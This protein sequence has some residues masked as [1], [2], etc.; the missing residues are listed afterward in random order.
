MEA[1]MT[2]RRRSSRAVANDDSIRS[3]T[4]ELIL[5]D[6]IDAISFRDVGREAGL[7]HGALYARYEDVEELLVDLWSELLCQSM[8]AL[9]DAARNAASNPSAETVDALLDYVRNAQT[10]DVVAVQVLLTS[11]RF[12][13]LHEEVEKFIHDYIENHEGVTRAV[14]SRALALFSLVAV[15]I[16]TNSQY[17][18]DVERIQFLRE[19][20]LDALK[21]DPEDVLQTPLTTPDRVVTTARSDIRSQ[22]AFHTFSAVGRSGFT[23]ATISRISRRANCSP[24]AIYKLYPSKDD[25]VVASMRALM[26]GPGITATRLAEILNE[27]TLAQYLYVAA[28]DQDSVRKFFNLEVLMASTQNEKLKSAVESQFER[29]YRFEAFV[30][31]IPDEERKKFQF[32]IREVIVLILGVSFLSTLTPEAVEIDFCQFAEPFRRA[33]LSHFE[34]WPEISR[35]LKDLSTTLP[36]RYQDPK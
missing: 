31:D 20:L 30:V 26:Q 16:F 14:Q 27:G 7:T 8:I 32:M 15:K 28:S 13:V 22:L 10:L 2:T 3:A 1:M 33:L 35:Q 11:R 4:A 29:L 6:G 17:G 23:R 9:V 25:L 21:T 19:V 34:S 36:Q 5:R 18:F 24:G 12:V